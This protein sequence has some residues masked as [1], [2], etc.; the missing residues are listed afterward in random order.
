MPISGQA[1]LLLAAETA[2][3]TTDPP[4]DGRF[5]PYTKGVAYC[6]IIGSTLGTLLCIW[7][8]SITVF[9]LHEIKPRWFREVRFFSLFCY[10]D[11]V[12]CLA[13]HSLGPSSGVI[14]CVKRADR[15]IKQIM[16]GSRL[17]VWLTTMTLALP[18][19]CITS[20][21]GTLTIGE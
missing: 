11:D 13:R 2:F 18:S 12:W 10:E 3:C 9:V 15:G 21:A 5:L 20:S 16:M 4:A 7:V 1:G 6:F 17:R 19:L 14:C 8:G